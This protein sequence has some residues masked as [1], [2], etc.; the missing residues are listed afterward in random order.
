MFN[1]MILQNRPVCAVYTFSRG[2]SVSAVA[3]T[4]GALVLSGSG[5]PR[6]LSYSVISSA[7]LAATSVIDPSV[8]L[9]PL[10]EPT[11]GLTS[12]SA[13]YLVSCTTRTSRSRA[14][15]CR[16]LFFRDA[17]PVNAAD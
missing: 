9:R 5:H 7:S 14:R 4:P 17:C 15:S 8:V 3:V 10:R 1:I 2:G 12:W 16:K 11:R 6:K 13:S